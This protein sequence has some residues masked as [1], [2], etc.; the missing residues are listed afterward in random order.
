VSAVRA[1]GLP[2]AGRNSWYLD[3]DRG[4]YRRLTA[5][6]RAELAGDG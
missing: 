4:K 1:T 5:A 6:A 3:P 2:K